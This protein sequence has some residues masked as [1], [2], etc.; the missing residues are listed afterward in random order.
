VARLSPLEFTEI[1]RV[2]LKDIEAID[3]PGAHTLKDDRQQERALELEQ[4]ALHSAAPLQRIEW[5]LHPFTT[6]AVLPAFA[7]ANAGI[8]LTGAG[9]GSPVALGIILG[10]VAGKLAGVALAAWLA[11]RTG[12]ADLP[13]GV[14]WR[15][16]IGAGALA[17]IGFT[18]SLFVA[19]LAFDTAVEADQAKSAIFVAS[20]VAGVIGY[21]MLRFWAPPPEAG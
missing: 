1:C 14:G 2:K 11:V 3:V 20:I 17:G 5:A 7:L 15:H 9:V 21:A 6:F 16:V 10:L 13:A 18:M 19:N 4:A 12:I 8:P